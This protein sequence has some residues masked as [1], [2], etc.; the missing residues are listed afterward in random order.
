[1]IRRF[2]PIRFNLVAL[3]PGDIL[4]RR[5]T[6]TSRRCLSTW[7]MRMLKSWGSHDAIIVQMNDG[8]L[9]IGESVSPRARVV[10]LSVWENQIN[11]G[12]ALVR[13]FRPIGATK[14]QGEKAA[15]WWKLNVLGTWYDWKAFPRLLLKCIF[16]DIFQWAAGDEWA[17]YCTEGIDPAWRIGGGIDI[18]QKVNPTPLTTEKRKMGTKPTLIEITD[19]IFL[20]FK[21]LYGVEPV[22]LRS[23]PQTGHYRQPE[24]VCHP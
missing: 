1:M 23:G 2:N 8:T 16:G 6:C 22:I 5:C 12:E 18:Y 11:D 13:V 20:K 7:I 3:Q 4:H 9:A 24:Q 15:A 14:E 19:N 10:P 17:W 21:L